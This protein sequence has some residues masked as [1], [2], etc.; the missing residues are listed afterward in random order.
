MYTYLRRRTRAEVDGLIEQLTDQ[1]HENL[2]DHPQP[3]IQITDRLTVVLP[4]E[5]HIFWLSRLMGFV[6]VIPL[7]VQALDPSVW[8]GSE[9]FQSDW[10]AFNGDGI[11]SPRSSRSHLCGEYSGVFLSPVIFSLGLQGA[12]WI[13]VQ[14]SSCSTMAKRLNS[15]SRMWLALEPI[16]A[17]GVTLGSFAAF[18]ELVNYIYEKVQMSA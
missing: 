9:L 10:L 5:Q 15:T 3:I 7:I 11:S 12:N 4:K 8:Q 18:K 14:Y 2:G 13:F 17:L 16:A 6:V 1:L